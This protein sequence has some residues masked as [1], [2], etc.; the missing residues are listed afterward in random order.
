MKLFGAIKTIVIIVFYL[1]YLLFSLL[2]IVTLLI[3]ILFGIALSRG[4]VGN[5]GFWV[6]MLCYTSFILQLIF[7]GSPALMLFEG[8]IIEP[9]ERKYKDI[10]IFGWFIAIFLL[11][12]IPGPSTYLWYR[13]RKRY[14][15]GII[16]P[17]IFIKILTWLGIRNKNEVQKR[18]IHDFYVDE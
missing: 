10:S 7:A 18:S 5:I 1:G 2:V 9:C 3:G 4:G 6:L 13:F 11:S 16:Q 15:H 14:V 17:N 8:R 12:W